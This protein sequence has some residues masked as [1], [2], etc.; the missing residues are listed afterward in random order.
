MPLTNTLSFA[1]AYA[2]A[3]AS[4][5]NGTAV[6]TRTLPSRQ[7]SAAPTRLVT[8]TTGRLMAMAGL[9]ATPSP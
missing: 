3:I 1:P 9:A 6:R 5:P 2:P 7:C 4:S 8:P